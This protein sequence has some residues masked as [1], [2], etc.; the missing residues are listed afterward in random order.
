M[1]DLRDEVRQRM[2]QIGS[3]NVP[4]AELERRWTKRFDR[5]LTAAEDFMGWC[6]R[7]GWRAR[8]KDG[9]VEARR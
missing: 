9:A 3:C 1:D 7:C 4:L 8:I 6:K 2:L 5:D